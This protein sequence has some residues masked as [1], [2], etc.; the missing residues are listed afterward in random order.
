MRHFPAEMWSMCICSVTLNCRFL[1]LQD[2]ML[3]R[4]LDWDIC[5]LWDGINAHQNSHL[6]FVSQCFMTILF[7]AL[8]T[9]SIGW[10]SP[11]HTYRHCSTHT[12]IALQAEAPSSISHVA[13][14]ILTRLIEIFRGIKW[15]AFFKQTVKE[16]KIQMWY[17]SCGSNLMWLRNDKHAHPAMQLANH[18]LTFS[19]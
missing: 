11:V 2:H 9:K 8:T 1:P 18:T 15:M 3:G 16:H 19:F 14:I 13:H 5:I 4:L 10:V 17:R 12:S 6:Y 7:Y